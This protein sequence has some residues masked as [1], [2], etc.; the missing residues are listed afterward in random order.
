M[1]PTKITYNICKLGWVR[2]VLP[3][4]W[5]EWFGWVRLEIE[6]KMLVCCALFLSSLCTHCCTTSH[7]FSSHLLKQS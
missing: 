1:S 2:W 4:H 3:A 6:L 7:D 5:K